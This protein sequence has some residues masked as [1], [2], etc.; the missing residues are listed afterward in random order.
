MSGQPEIPLQADEIVVMAPGED[1]RRKL[2]STAQR[3][4]GSVKPLVRDT[5]WSHAR[6]DAPR[7]VGRQAAAERKL[8]PVGVF[9][10]ADPSQF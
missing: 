9:D 3:S 7:G 4:G 8:V 1:E 6:L 10:V 5:P 2:L